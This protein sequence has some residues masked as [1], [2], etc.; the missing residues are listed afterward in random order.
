MVWFRE[1]GVVHMGDLFFPRMLPF[2]DLATGGDAVSLERSIADA[3]TFLPA[4]ARVIPGHGALA[5]TEDVREY[6]R[7]LVETI[8]HV[9]QGIAAGRSLEELQ[10]AGLPEPW[11]EWAWAFVDEATW[12]GIVHASLTGA[13]EGPASSHGH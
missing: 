7:M 2:V 4:D 9:R 8:D 5:T 1:S 3:L 6:H 12:I 13:E 10:A 11:N